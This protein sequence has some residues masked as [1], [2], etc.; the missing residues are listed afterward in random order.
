MKFPDGN[1]SG[2]YKVCVGGSSQD[3]LLTGSV[4]LPGS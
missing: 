3:T 1:L 4:R 2:G